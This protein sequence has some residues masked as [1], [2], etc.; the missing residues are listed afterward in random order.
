MLKF[1]YKFWT[2]GKV[3]H[4]CKKFYNNEWGAGRS[5][6]TTKL[7]NSD[8]FKTSAVAQALTTN[9]GK[10][11]WKGKLSTVYLLVLPVD[12]LVLTADL[13][14]LTS[15]DQLLFVLKILLTFFS[16]QATSMR[17]SSVLSLPSQLA[18]HG[19]SCKQWNSTLLTST[20]LPL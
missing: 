16:R 10:S 11:H 3:N 18:F 8:C 12:L 15:L 13:L 17:R 6:T 9:P 1:K 7:L 20:I 14:V 2:N 5:L 4:F 19:Q